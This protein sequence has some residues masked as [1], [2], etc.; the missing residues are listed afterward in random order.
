MVTKVEGSY[1]TAGDSVD[2]DY[3]DPSAVTVN[4]LVDASRLV[5]W[6]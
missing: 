1:D 4:N 2:K 6:N 5:V 3:D